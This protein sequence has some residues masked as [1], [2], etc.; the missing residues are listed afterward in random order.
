M[1]QLEPQVQSKGF[2]FEIIERTEFAAI[3]S[4]KCTVSGK[5][6]A[7]EVFRIGKNEEREI[8]GVKIAASESRPGNEAFGTSAW[9][10]SVS[11]TTEAAALERAM[12]H[13]REFCQ[14]I[15]NKLQTN[16]L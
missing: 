7:F 14:Q 16:N 13:Y 12:K 5:L 8:S 6:V 9:C 1:K 15:E 10:Y 4:Q 2:V 3:Q 11:G